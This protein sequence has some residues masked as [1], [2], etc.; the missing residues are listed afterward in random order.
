MHSN[1]DEEDVVSEEEEI[2]VTQ[3]AIADGTAQPALTFPPVDAPGGTEIE[4]DGRACTCKWYRSKTHLRR[5]HKTV[6]VI[7]KKDLYLGKIL[8]GWP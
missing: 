2:C 5:S 8:F 6:N 7:Q 4:V 3:A 1:G